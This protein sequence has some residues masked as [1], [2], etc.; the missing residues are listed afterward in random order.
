MFVLLREGTRGALDELLTT[1]GMS[2]GPCQLLSLCT[3]P[4]LPPPPTT[5]ASQGINE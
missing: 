4:P 2:S 3:Q 5:S 1:T